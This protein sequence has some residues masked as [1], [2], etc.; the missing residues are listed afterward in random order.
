[1]CSFSCLAF[2]Q[3]QEI[4]SRGRQRLLDGLLMKYGAG[5]TSQSYRWSHPTALCLLLFFQ[6][7]IQLRL[8]F[9]GGLRWIGSPRSC[10]FL[11]VR[12]NALLWS[13]RQASATLVGN[14][15]PIRR[16]Y[17]CQWCLDS[18][19]PSSHDGDRIHTSGKQKT[20]KAGFLRNRQAFKNPFLSVLGD[21]SW[22]CTSGFL[23]GIAWQTE[24]Q[25]HDHTLHLWSISSPL[26]HKHQLWL[27]PWPIQTAFPHDMMVGNLIETMVSLY[28]LCG[29]CGLDRCI[30]N[31][32]P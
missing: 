11:P 9:R 1:M 26:S 31:A 19:D 17:Q 16:V 15:L 27:K 10:G 13:Y 8:R 6:G 24:S 28:G 12:A 29:N 20:W 18:S 4:N 23:P 21:S 25:P 2:A 3:F 14:P 30:C 7:R 22:L 32:R 5:V